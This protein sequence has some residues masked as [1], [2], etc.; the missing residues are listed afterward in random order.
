MN[1]H[2]NDYTEQELLDT[3]CC[4]CDNNLAEYACQNSMQDNEAY[5]VECCEFPCCVDEYTGY[6]PE[7]QGERA[8]E[9]NLYNYEREI[10][11]EI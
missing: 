3:T 1:K 9:W 10:V 7:S 8:V 5:C 6:E 2:L 4:M 11:K